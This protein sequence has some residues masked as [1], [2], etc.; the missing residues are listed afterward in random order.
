MRGECDYQHTLSINAAQ[1]DQ[2][3]SIFDVIIQFIVR[4]ACIEKSFLP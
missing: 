2:Q 3:F 1:D 4:S